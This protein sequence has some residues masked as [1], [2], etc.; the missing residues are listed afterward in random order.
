M[1]QLKNGSIY[2]YPTP[3]EDIT[4]GLKIEGFVNLP[5]VTVSSTEADIFG[6]NTA[7]R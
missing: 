5:D 2:I 3:T 7:L 4:D 1:Y 6:E